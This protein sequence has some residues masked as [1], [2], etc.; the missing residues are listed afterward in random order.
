VRTNDDT[1]GTHEVH[2]TN[3]FFT[4]IFRNKDYSIGSLHWNTLYG[5]AYLGAGTVAFEASDLNEPVVDVGLGTES[6]MTF[7]DYD[8][9]LSFL[10]AQTVVK[11]DD[12]KGGTRVLFAIR[13]SR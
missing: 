8:I 10:V 3:E 12:L 4:P 7:G 5:V 13:T 11:P 6:A 1:I 2:L 9:F